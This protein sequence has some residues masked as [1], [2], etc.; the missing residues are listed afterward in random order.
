M[1]T[2]E[3]SA[4]AT[5]KEVKKRKSNKTNIGAYAPCLSVTLKGGQYIRVP[6]DK[7]SSDALRGILVAK[8]RDFVEGHVDRLANASLTPAE[9]KDLVRAISDVDA[10]QREQY[11][12]SLNASSSDMGKG[13]QS[14]IKNAAQGAAEVTAAGF[15]DKMRR[16]DEA[17]K[18]IEKQVVPI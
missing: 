8:A 10:L 18:K 17:A 2:T 4:V 1:E 5:V 11:V 13:M 3:S 15:M 7:A 6:V 9:I 12:I 16:M 14:M